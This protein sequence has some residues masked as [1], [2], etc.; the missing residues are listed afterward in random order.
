MTILTPS[1]KWSRGP[2]ASASSPTASPS[3]DPV[4]RLPEHRHQLLLRR[5]RLGDDVVLRQTQSFGSLSTDTSCSSGDAG[6]GT[7]LYFHAMSGGA[8]S[9]MDSMRPPSR[10]KRTP[11]SYSRLNSAGGCGGVQHAVGAAGEGAG[12]FLPLFCSALCSLQRA[13]GSRYFP[14]CVTPPLRARNG[15]CRTPI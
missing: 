5:P 9:M 14:G 4:F 2:A 11:R 13:T 10:P 15:S 3:S 7:T 6:S 12:S 1:T 8:E